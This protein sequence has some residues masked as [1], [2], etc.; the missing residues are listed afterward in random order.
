[1]NDYKIEVRDPIHGNILLD[2]TESRIIDTPEMQRLRYIKQLDMSY[3]I[4]PGANHTRF[5]HSL[6]AMQVTKELVSRTYGDDEKEFPYVGLLHDIGHGPFSHLSEH[7]IK[8]I[9]GRNHEQIGEDIIRNSEI[10]DIISDSGM[11]FKK[12]M[13]YFNEADRIDIVGG[14]LGSDRIDYLMRDS[15]YT[16]VAYGIIDYDRI[17]SRIV[18]SGDRIAILESGISGAE[19][20]Q[21]ARYF[22]HSNVYT[23][24]AKLIASRMLHRAIASAIENRVFDV[25]RLERMYDDELIGRLLNSGIEET[26]R[27]ARR[28]MER[29][30]F[31]RAYYGKLH[32][33]IHAGEIEDAI[34]KAG[35][36]K[37]SFIVHIVSLGGGSDDINVVDS[38][39][40]HVGRLTELSPLMQ[41]LSGMLSGSRRL[42]VACDEKDVNSIS[43]IVKRALG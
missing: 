28:V 31:K 2:E 1:M 32:R 7:F 37:S 21:I 34:E 17:K 13:S 24:H 5:E 27:M 43:G 26:A 35:Y 19:S 25:G 36:G 14:I 22:M 15:Y 42:M 11:S 40:N 23:H 38:D 20:I 41:T 6:G 3:L 33:D 39:G 16:G 9:A 30:L 29:Q 12:I 10:K 8:E 18:L 4:F